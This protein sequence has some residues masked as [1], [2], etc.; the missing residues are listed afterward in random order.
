MS[1]FGGKADIE[2]IARELRFAEVTNLDRLGERRFVVLGHIPSAR[3]ETVASN[4][5]L[6]NLKI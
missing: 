3:L 4:E 1:A 5:F 2:A 6:P